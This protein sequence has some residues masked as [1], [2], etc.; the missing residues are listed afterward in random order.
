MGIIFF[1]CST[2][3]STLKEKEKIKR[4]VFYKLSPPSYQ[5]FFMS[6]AI[7][8]V[9]VQDQVSQTLTFCGLE[10]KFLSLNHKL[11]KSLGSARYSITLNELISSKVLRRFFFSSGKAR[12]IFRIERI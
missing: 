9:H 3:H 10:D 7:N 12:F 8:G 1:F 11:V 2:H 4:N 5:F 6:I